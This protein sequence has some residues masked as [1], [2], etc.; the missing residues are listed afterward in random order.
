LRTIY[1]VDAI[2]GIQP[3]LEGRL[4]RVVD[5]ELITRH[6]GGAGTFATPAMIGLMEIT[7]HRS[8]EPL[9]P[10]GHT[11]VGYEVHVRHLAPAAPGSTVL[12]TT[13]VTEVK[14]NKLYFDVECRQGDKLIGSGMH[15]RAIVPAE[16]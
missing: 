15:E 11:T 10:A 16:F 14:G 3:G 8:V 2:D 4:E 5:G 7:S 13:K 12:V 6:V 9:L 1:L